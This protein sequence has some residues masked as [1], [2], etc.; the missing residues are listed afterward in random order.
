MP[1]KT[2]KRQNQRSYGVI[3][4]RIAR[5]VSCALL[6]MESAVWSSQQTTMQRV[7]VLDIKMVPQQVNCK[8]L[9]APL[10]FPFFI[11]RS[12]QVAIIML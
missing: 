7:T 3:Q 6:A 8:D 9:M 4:P 12:N 5:M 2:P 1:H 11:F 10:P